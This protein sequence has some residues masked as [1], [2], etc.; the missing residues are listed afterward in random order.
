MN[1][2]QNFKEGCIFF[3]KNDK[4]LEAAM[5]LPNGILLDEGF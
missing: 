1:D 2:C 4:I 5:R 3:I